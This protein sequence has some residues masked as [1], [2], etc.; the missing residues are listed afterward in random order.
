L[1]RG[2]KATRSGQ[3]RGIP[4]RGGARLD[5]GGTG[6]DANMAQK[7]SERVGGITVQLSHLDKGF[8]PGDGIMS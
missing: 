6:N 2:S 1:C 7:P 4:G 3:N 8:F 5:R